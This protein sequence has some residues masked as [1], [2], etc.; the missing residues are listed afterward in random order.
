MSAWLSECVVASISN[1]DKLIKC[2]IKLGVRG[3]N[4][5]RIVNNALAP[6]RSR[7]AKAQSQILK[8]KPKTEGK[9]AKTCAFVAPLFDVYQHCCARELFK[10]SRDVVKSQPECLN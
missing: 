5:I 3:K 8:L 6:T 7:C 4:T 9:R 1:T 2:L 10:I